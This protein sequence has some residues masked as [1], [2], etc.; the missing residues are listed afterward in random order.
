MHPP[1]RGPNVALRQIST[2][3]VPLTITQSAI[4]LK[5]HQQTLLGLSILG[6]KSS[7]KKILGE[8]SQA[9]M[10]HCAVQM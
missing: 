7:N 4:K 6:K 1:L 8:N 10:Q 2:T 3:T 9:K 5:S